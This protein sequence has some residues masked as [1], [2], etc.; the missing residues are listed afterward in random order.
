VLGKKLY[1]SPVIDLFNQEI[2]SY[3]I[4]ERP[5]FKSVFDM[6]KSAIRKTKGD[7]E[8]MLHSDQGWQYQMRRYQELLKK[9]NIVQSMSRKGN[10]WDNAIMENFFGV[11][12]TELFYLKKYRSINELKK[13]I[14][15]YIK[16]YNNERIK[17]N[18][19]G[20]SPIEYRAHH[21]QINN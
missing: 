2:I 4:S 15:E 6:V 7:H 8:I 12:K 16:Y 20:M 14:V 13:E 11:V 17:T 3:K 1:L 5:D 9:S 10:C 21:I 18:L 19:K